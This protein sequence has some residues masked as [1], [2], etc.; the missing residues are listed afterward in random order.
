MNRIG[1]ISRLFIVAVAASGNA[2]AEALVWTG[3]GISKTA[4]MEDVSKAYEEQ[5]GTSILLTGGGATKGIRSVAEGKNQLGGACRHRMKDKSGNLIAEEADARLTQ[6]AWDAI[7]VIVHPDNPVNNISM[8]QLKA[9]YSGRVTNWRE[10]GGA[11]IPIALIVR[12]G[13]ES[14]V[15]Y[16]FRRMVMNHVDYEFPST[17]INVKSSGPL[18]AEIETNVAGFAIDGV[19][20]AKKR[21]VKTL[22]LDAIAPSKA[23]IANGTYPLFRPLYIVTD[24]IHVSEDAQKFVQFVLSDTGQTV[25]SSSGTVN[26]VEGSALNSKWDAKKAA[27]GL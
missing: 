24:D 7:V 23:N 12:E 1:L 13:K 17:A 10:L 27:L 14:G 15:G 2:S 8:E 21:K 25:I 9:V 11:D 5:T 26:L 18:E 3:C 20:S 19:S 22:S 4:F 16:M 6:V